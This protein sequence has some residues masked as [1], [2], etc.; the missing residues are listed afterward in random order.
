MTINFATPSI[1]NKEINNVTKVL[2]SGWLTTGSQTKNLESLINQYI[3]SE[4]CLCLN[5]CTSALHLALICAGIKAGDEV[6]TTPFTFVST[7]NTILYL[8]AKPVFVDI[9]PQDFVIDEDKIESKITKK[10]KAILPVHY[11]GFSANLDKLS[12]LCKKYNLTLIEDAAHA[13]G[14]KY[15]NRFIGR[16]SRFCCFSFYPTKNITTGEGGALVTNDENVYKKALSLS[17]HGINKGN[18][19]K[20]YSTT[21]SWKY[22]VDKLGF[23]YNMTDLQATLGIAQ[24]GRINILKRRRDIIYQLYKEGLSEIKGIEILSGNAYSFPF[25]HLFV[26]KIKS[27]K[28]KR[29][30]FIEIMKKKNIVCSVHFIPVYKFTLYKE[31][32]VKNSE[33]PNCETAYKDCLSLPF[34]AVMGIKET[35]QVIKVIKN[36]FKSKN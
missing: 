14:S 30:D 2:N 12:L 3:G 28:I 5:S 27:K 17:L 4:F 9:K 18:A 35:W 6:I 24:L 21:G 34:N 23:K 13:F 20:R 36:I 19:W 16:S 32:L 1:T 7:I 25:R 15:R 29:D 26:I 10:T 11:A 31:L 8:R 22:D 33:F